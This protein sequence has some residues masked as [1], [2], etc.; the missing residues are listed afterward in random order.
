[1]EQLQDVRQRASS[2]REGVTSR[3]LDRL[4]DPVRRFGGWLRSDDFFTTSSSLAYYA[5]ISLAPMALIALWIAGALIDEDS[6]R[7]LG[8]TVDGESPEELPVGELVQSLVALATTIGFFSVIG[9]I[10][11]A[12]AYGAALARAF[13][14]ITP[15]A[16]RQVRGMKGRV[17][18]AL[19]IAVLPLAVFGALAVL[20]V[21]PR[22][23]GVSG[24]WITATLGLGA[25]LFVWLFIS[26]I[27]QLFQMRDTQWTDVL[28]AAAAATG[29]LAVVSAGYLVYLEFFA[30]FEE[31]YGTSGLATI[32]LLG[33]WLMLA[34]AVLLVGYKLMLRR[35]LARAEGVSGRDAYS[36]AL[37]GETA[38]ADAS[39]DRRLPADRD[40]ERGTGPAPDAGRPA[41]GQGSRPS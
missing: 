33:V 15:D 36:A 2:V 31:R 13:D 17:F 23:L 20:Y 34:N 19:L 10:W 21:V 39:D 26:G 41:A 27:Y 22:L 40:G 29:V 30:D 12:T 38:E 8:S 18:A 14:H 7:E 3:T 4:P 16:E 1:V 35:A 24:L 9:A 37:A 32:V 6:L 5:L 28:V 11:P 25:A